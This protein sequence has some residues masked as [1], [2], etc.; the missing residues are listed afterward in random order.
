MNRCFGG[1]FRHQSTNLSTEI[2]DVSQGWGCFLA[3]AFQANWFGNRLAQIEAGFIL[4]CQIYVKLACS[5]YK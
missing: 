5:P 4:K 2:V 1:L 3:A